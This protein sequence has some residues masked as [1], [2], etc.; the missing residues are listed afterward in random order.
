[1]Q[2]AK[3]PVSDLTG[4]SETLLIPLIARAQ[5]RTR[6]PDLGFTDLAAER[7]LSQLDVDPHRFDQHVPTMR[8]AI[9]RAQAFDRIAADFA[10]AHPGGRAVSLGAGLDTRAERVAAGQLTWADIDLPVVTG[11]R[12]RLLPATA[13]Q[14]LVAGSVTDPAWTRQ[15]GW[16]PGRPLLLIAEAVLMFLQPAEVHAF[17]TGLPGQ[18]P[19]GAE[20]ALDYGAPLMINNTDRHPGLKNTTARFQW[21]ACGARQIAQLHPR[22]RVLADRNLS[23][24]AVIPGPQG[25]TIAATSRSLRATTGGWLY[26]LAHLAIQPAPN[27]VSGADRA[28][29]SGSQ[30]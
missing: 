9:I 23:S 5:A 26:G 17:L 29:Q 14:R 2:Y 24:S 1:M 21:S 12:E 10:A 4:V 6:F 16:E 20:I 22:L 25:H 28:R 13:G 27:G 30:Q 15:I 7:V 11:L 8:G 3:V 18:F 19:T